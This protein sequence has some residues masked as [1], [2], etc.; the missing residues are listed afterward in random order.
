MISALHREVKPT[1]ALKNG[2]VVGS[3]RVIGSPLENID[4]IVL[5]REKPLQVPRFSCVGRVVVHVVTNPFLDFSSL[6]QSSYGITQNVL[7]VSPPV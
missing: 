7:H 2:L 3:R 1:K 6:E 4:F 5:A